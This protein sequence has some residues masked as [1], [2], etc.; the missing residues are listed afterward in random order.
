MKSKPMQKISRT[1]ES[2]M[3]CRTSEWSEG[4]R[5]G[6]KRN[7]EVLH[8]RAPNEGGPGST[9]EV[10]PI[11][12]RRRFSASY[13]ASIVREASHCT[14][15]GEIGALLRREGLYSSQLS[16]WRLRYANGEEDGLQE[17]KRGR[18]PQDALVKE[19]ERLRRQL[20]KKE[21]E[22]KQAQ[23]LIELQ[24]KMAEIWGTVLPGTESSGDEV[25]NL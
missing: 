10:L 16:A 15:P 7:G 4:E 14:K 2:P 13:K 8:R 11:P 19:N 12:K 5:S 9:T 6:P 20:A 1:E 22:L 25:C 18:K 21:K 17:Q 3:R 23:L 24:K